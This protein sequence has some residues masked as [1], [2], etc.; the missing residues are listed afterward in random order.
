MH[1]RQM[2]RRTFATTLGAALV[3]RGAAAMPR[4][5]DSVWSGIDLMEQSGRSFG[6]SQAATPLT[7]LK[8]WAHWC[9]ACLTEIAP[10]A[11]MAAAVGPRKLEVLLVS[12]PEYWAQDQEAA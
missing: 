12:H 9:P 11:A 8:L 1:T 7:L 10:L 5:E 4:P 6:L 2:N 3:A